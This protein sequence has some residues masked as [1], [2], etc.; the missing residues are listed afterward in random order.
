M[1][2]LWT[3]NTCYFRIGSH[4]IISN[5]LREPNAT[6][7]FFL[8]IRKGIKAIDALHTKR[9]IEYEGTAQRK[10]EH[11]HHNCKTKAAMWPHLRISQISELETNKLMGHCNFLEISCE[12][13]V[14][15]WRRFSFLFG[16][17]D[18]FEFL[19]VAWT[20]H[21]GPRE[22]FTRHSPSFT[23]SHISVSQ[24]DKI[25]DDNCIRC[26]ESSMY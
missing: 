15:A 6:S 22:L 21:L 3:S 2:S 5:R 18:F 13:V 11:V 25:N 9:N 7:T 23:A 24:E 26:S 19:I 10:R 16:S 20:R 14:V 17:L 12:V 1:K 8:K 4:E